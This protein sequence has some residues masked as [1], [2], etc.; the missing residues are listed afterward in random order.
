LLKKEHTE[1]EQKLDGL[2]DLRLNGEL[3]KEEFQVKKQKLKDRQ[4]EIS[5][6]LLT[7]DK[8][9]D[10]FT[11]TATML[12]NIASEALETFVSSE[13]AKKREMLNFIFQN[14]KLEGQKLL[15]TLRFP[16]DVFEKTTTRPEWLGR[17]DSNQRS[18]Y[19]KPMPYR[20]AT[21]Q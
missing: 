13:L 2:T 21:P 6:L 20:L 19:Q 10:K 4:Y 18:R 1:I 5:E 12:I 8:A 14:C 15:Y 7:Y 16:F 17:L 11:E 9:D 3:T